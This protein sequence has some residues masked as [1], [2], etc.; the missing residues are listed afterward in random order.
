MSQKTPGNKSEIELAQ[1]YA[2]ITLLHGQKSTLFESILP[3]IE[4]VT[5]WF[6]YLHSNNQA[7][8]AD[9]MLYNIQSNM[10][11]KTMK[12]IEIKEVLV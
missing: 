8:G 9:T 5:S 7:N 6:L 3:E 11:S 2:L 10:T 12:N 1:S 4:P